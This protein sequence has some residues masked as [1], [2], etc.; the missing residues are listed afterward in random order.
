MELVSQRL[1]RESL[2]GDSDS[3]MYMEDYNELSKGD[4]SDNSDMDGLLYSLVPL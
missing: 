3:V 4:T 1:P 2:K